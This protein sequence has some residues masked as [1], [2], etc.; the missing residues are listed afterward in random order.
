MALPACFASAPV[1]SDDAFI[2]SRPLALSRGY[3]DWK[4]AVSA[5]YNEISYYDWAKPGWREST[6]H[7]TQLIWDETTAVGCAL[8][9][10]C[11]QA[12]FVCHYSPVGALA[13]TKTGFCQCCA[14]C[15]GCMNPR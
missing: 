13:G 15:T 12:T 10:A 7:F 14:W 6:G 3:P 5:W 8:N 1:R 2:P 11:K 9:A 4:D